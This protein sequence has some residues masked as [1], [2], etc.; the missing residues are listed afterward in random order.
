[1]II[2]GILQRNGLIATLLAE[3]YGNACVNIVVVVQ[4]PVASDFHRQKFRVFKETTKN[5]Q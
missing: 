4:S 1:M 2:L 3:L 5:A